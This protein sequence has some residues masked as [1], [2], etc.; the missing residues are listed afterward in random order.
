MRGNRAPERVDDSRGVVDRKRGLRDVRK[1]GRIRDRETLDVGDRFDEMDAAFALAHRPSTS[2]CPAWPII[3]IVAAVIAHP[4]DFDMDL[5]DERAGG[6]EYTRGPRASA[7]A[8]TAFEHTVRREHDRAA[9]RD[10]VQL[11]DE[12]RAL[13]LE[14]VDDELVVD[15]LVA[16]VD[17]RAELRKRL[18]DDR[19]RAVDT[20]AKAAWIGEHDVHQLPRPDGTRP[21]AR[22]CMKLSMISSAAP[23][24]DRAV[25]DVERRPRPA[26]VVEKQEV[27]HA[28]R[29]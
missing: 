17:R 4:G 25:G 20:G 21:F 24:A 27:D 6:V 15:D 22:R 13:R 12:H 2:G 28:D 19:D 9:G 3:T 7:S 29:S 23:I 14:V 11:L 5:G 26:L 10:F 18:L 8:R 16:D 1:I